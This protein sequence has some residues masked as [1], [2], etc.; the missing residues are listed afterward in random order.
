MLLSRDSMFVEQ[1]A[2]GRNRLYSRGVVLGGEYAVFE[3]ERFAPPQVTSEERILES[4]F[5][6]LWDSYSMSSDA[7]LSRANSAEEAFNAEMK[8]LLSQTDGEPDEGSISMVILAAGYGTRFSAEA[9]RV[10][11]LKGRPKAL[12]PIDGRPVLEWLL[13]GVKDIKEIQR[14]IVVTNEKYIEQFEN[15]KARATEPRY[16]DPNHFKIISDG[17]RSIEEKR[18]AIGALHFAVTRED[19]KGNVLVAGADNFFEGSFKELVQSFLNKKVGMVVTHDEGSTDKIAGR[20]GAVKQDITGRIIDFEEKPQYPKSTF[21]STFCYLLT[22]E[23]L[24]HLKGYVRGGFSSDN[25]GEFIK[26]LV[27]EGEVLEAFQ[28]AGEWNDVGTFAEYRNLR[29]NIERPERTL[30]K[31]VGKS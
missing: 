24:Q 12:L 5:E 8:A 9:D 23:N 16:R 30:T 14:I 15:W 2:Y 4:A 29:D 31:G 27:T 17:T 1:Y 7:Y 18:G 22:K 21:A 19:I 28:Y 3:H 13:E 20:L 10:P 11:E 25:A 26:H 6:V